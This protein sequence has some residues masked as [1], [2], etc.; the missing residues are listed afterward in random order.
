MLP[1]THDSLP[2]KLQA[3]LSLRTISASLRTNVS[4]LTRPV[5]AARGKG[6]RVPALLL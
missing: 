4:S 1:S 6:V 3:I 2:C 5:L